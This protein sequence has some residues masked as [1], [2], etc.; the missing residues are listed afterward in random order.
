MKEISFN[1]KYLITEDGEIYSK[2]K[3]KFL[4]V[5][6]DNSGYKRVNLWCPVEGKTK[7]FLVHRLIALTYLPRIDGLDYVNH[8]NGNKLDNRLENLEWCT[9]SYNQKHAISLGLKGSSKGEEN[10]RA[11]LKDFQVLEIYA[12]LLEG[13]PF[14]YLC[15]EYKVS[16]TVVSEIKRKVRW[17]HLT[18]NLSDIPIKPKKKGLD[19][20]IVIKVCELLQK[21]HMPKFIV[22]NLL[23]DA[24]YDQVADIRRRR[25]HINISGNYKW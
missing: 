21:G 19:K 17:K 10:G 6:A 18:E 23:D 12:Y 7:K 4:S 2:Y 16:R 13:K 20:E 8:K 22:D 11:I 1:N 24:T 14:S 9:S 5:S 25:C 3:N 15:K